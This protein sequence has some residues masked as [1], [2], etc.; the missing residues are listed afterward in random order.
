MS[1]GDRI[2]KHNKL[3][4]LRERDAADFDV[5]TLIAWSRDEEHE[6]RDWATYLLGSELDIDTPEVRR[7]LRDRLEDEDFDTRCEALVG[8]AR[9]RDEQAV[10]P[11]LRA[12]QGLDG[13]AVS[14][15]MVEAAGHFGRAEF[16]PVLERLRSWWDVDEELLEK[17]IA[18]CSGTRRDWW[19]DTDGRVRNDE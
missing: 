18:H 12:L 9:R 6:V 19:W 4:L 5:G 13:E 2:A 14:T 3:L 7:A 16:V 17:A 10:K 11:V 8:L 1:R 15:M